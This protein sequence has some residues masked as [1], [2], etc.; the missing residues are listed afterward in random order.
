MDATKK[1]LRIPPEFTTYA[2]RH[3]IFDLYKRLIERVIINKPEDPL[4]FLIEELKKDNDD[5]PAIL[6]HGPPASGKRTI[7]KLV[8]SKLRSAHITPQNILEDDVSPTVARAKE[9]LARKEEIP[10]ALWVELIQNRL[11]LFDCV[12]KGWVLEGFP[13]TREQARALQTVGIHPKHFVLLDAPDT[14]LIERQMGKRIDPETENVYHTTFDWPN[15]PELVNRLVEPDD[16]NEDAM[17]NR[18]VV[19]HRHIDGILDCYSKVTKKINADQPKSDV[20]SQAWTFLNSQLRTAAPHTPRIVILGPTGSGKKTQAALLASKYHCVSVS[21]GQLV[22]EAIANES[23]MGEA[24]KPYVERDMMIPDNLILNLLKDRLCQIDCVSR[25]W[26]LRGF[27]TTREQAEN[28]CS[29]GFEP[30]RTFFLDVPNDSVI[31]RLVLRTTDPITGERYHELY[32]PPRTQEIKDRCRQ[33][34]KDTEEEV[35]KRLASYQAYASE[36][37]DFYESAQHVNADQDPHTVFECLESML[38]NPLPKRYGG[39]DQ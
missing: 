3:G 9:Y 22:K 36:I 32:N 10:T 5:V 39:G 35:K 21:T 15:D 19:Y 26:V 14:V 37:A 2:E 31:E 7:A 4:E 6:I 1:P 27:P 20:F 33:H 16:N 18:L 17:V 11:K 12:K 23:K 8:C 34:V 28:L 24:L 25:G 30:N 13:Q 29:A 38:V